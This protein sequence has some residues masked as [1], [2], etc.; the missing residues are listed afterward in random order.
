MNSLRSA[1]FQADYM[2]LDISDDLSIAK[3]M[4]NIEDDT[5]IAFKSSDPTPFQEQAELTINPNFFGTLKVTESLLPLLRKTEAPRI[6]NIGSQIGHLKLFKSED[7]RA[8]FENCA[9]L[10]ELEGLINAYISDVKDGTHEEKG[11]PSSNYG[12]SKAGVIA[13]TRVLAAREKELFPDS[14][15][16]INVCCPGYCDTDMTSHK[17]T[18]TAEHGARTPAMLALTDAAELPSGRFFVDEAEVEW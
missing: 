6:V 8:R 12:I 16:R 11:W 2:N 13:L 5:E 18:R 7:K 3:F 14:H 1:G 15:M 4:R 9:S 17:G 10:D